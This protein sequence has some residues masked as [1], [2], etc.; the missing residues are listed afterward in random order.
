[1]PFSALKSVQCV[2][3]AASY[4]CASSQTLQLV[5]QPGE[6]VAA[7]AN[8]FCYASDNVVF[9]HAGFDISSWLQ[10]IAGG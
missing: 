5:L 1:V 2:L 7:D 6:E 10:G 9:E 4:A 8:N 3:C